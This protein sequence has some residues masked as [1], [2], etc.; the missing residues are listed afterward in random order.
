MGGFK[1][2]NKG[3]PAS[4]DACMFGKRTDVGLHL[5]NFKILYIYK[6]LENKTKRDHIFYDEVHDLQRCDIVRFIWNNY[7]IYYY[8]FLLRSV[9]ICLFLWNMIDINYTR[10]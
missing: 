2:K 4:D 3:I 5:Y 10:F 7:N 6:I 9:L 8:F 1:K